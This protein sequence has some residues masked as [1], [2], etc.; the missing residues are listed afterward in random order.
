MPG[1][2]NRSKTRVET[3]EEVH[4]IIDETRTVAAALDDLFQRV[5]RLSEPLWRTGWTEPIGSL[6]G[7]GMSLRRWAAKLEDAADPDEPAT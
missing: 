7:F 2:V 3:A 4:S 1:P 6:G 5:D